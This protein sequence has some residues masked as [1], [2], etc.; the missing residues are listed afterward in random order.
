VAAAQWLET[1]DAALTELI[2][3]GHSP[4]H[5]ERHHGD[6]VG[7]RSRNAIISRCRRLKLQLSSN[8][9]VRGP[10]IWTK[11]RFAELT[12][13]YHGIIPYSREEIANKLGVT[14]AAIHKGIW[15]LRAR[16]AKARGHVMP[17]K[18]RRP[19]IPNQPRQPRPQPP[20]QAAPNSKPVGFAE[21]GKCHCRYIVAGEGFQAQFCGAQQWADSPYCGFHHRL[22]HQAA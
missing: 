3:A 10:L 16:E 13:L 5:I 22:C 11:E 7:H 2:T 4:G 6:R 9:N 14:V 17:R 8:G 1:E 21:L 15:K 20:M 12:R 19:G 18:V